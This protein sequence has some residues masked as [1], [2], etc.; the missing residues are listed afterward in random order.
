MAHVGVLCPG[1]PGHINPLACLAREL[2]KRGHKVTAFQ[3]PEAEA[4]VSRSGLAHWSV[5]AR[6]FPHGSIAAQY[7]KLGSLEGLA[8]LRFLIAFWIARSRMLFDEAPE[9]AQQAGIDLLLVDQAELAGASVADRLK[10]PFITVS[11]AL[12]ANR[13]PGIPPIFTGW[14]YPATVFGKLRNQ[15][16]YRFQERLCRNWLAVHNEQRQKWGLPMYRVFEDGTSPWAHV[17]QQPP[18]FDFPRRHLPPQFHYTGP[19]HDRSARPPIPFPYE[20]LNGGRII[21]ASMGTLQ[22][23][24]QSVFREIAQG[25]QGLDAQL[26]ISLGGGSTPEQLGQLPGNP[27]V[28]AEAPQLELLSRA[29]LTIT[30][31]GLNTALESLSYGVP[32]V[33]IPVSTDQPGVAARVKWLGAG[34]VISLKQLRADR[35]RQLLQRVL[36]QPSYTFQAKRLQEIFQ[37]AN[38]TKTAVD[39]IERVLKDRRPVLRATAAAK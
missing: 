16:A 13:E 33:A 21:Y 18:A 4:A 12:V 11:N 20:K 19:W 3:P 25:C 34:E 1:V 28:V 6:V 32:M 9:A 38:G 5:G 37:A 22:N 24:I 39:I 29:S 10:L 23:R 35:L 30:H 2:Q 15:L 36:A 8:A 14:S 31:A 26:V 7:A 17:S 27:I